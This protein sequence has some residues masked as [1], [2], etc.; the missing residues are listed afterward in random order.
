MF[1]KSQS[2]L[3]ILTS[4]RRP[5]VLLF[6][7]WVLRNLEHHFIIVVQIWILIINIFNH[8]FTN[9]IGSIYLVF[10]ICWVDFAFKHRL[11]IDQFILFYLET[12]QIFD[13]TDD[14]FFFYFFEKLWSIFQLLNKFLFI[15][16]H[17]FQAFLY[18]FR[19]MNHLIFQSFAFIVVHHILKFADELVSSEE[20]KDFGFFNV[21]AFIF[22]KF[23]LDIYVHV[24]KLVEISLFHFWIGHFFH[25]V[26]FF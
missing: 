7:I 24:I 20:E 23:T 4:I 18:N 11:L 25:Q 26:R 1:K 22:Q 2:V 8:R 19:Y 13:S 17:L 16:I 5:L 15:K 6:L 12:A 10:M 9:A 3:F 21:F 14:F